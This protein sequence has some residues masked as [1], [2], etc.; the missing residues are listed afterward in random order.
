MWETDNTNIHWTNGDVLTGGPDIPSVILTVQQVMN[1][2]V[3]ATGTQGNTG[4]Q[5]ATGPSQWIN[6]NGIGPQGAGYTGIG[7]TGQD[8]L[9]Y[10]NL[11]VT[12]AID[13]TSL[14][15]SQ[16]TGGPQGSIWYDTNNFIRMDKM[17]IDDSTS[18]I[19]LDINSSLPQINLTDLS[20]PPLHTN[21]ITNER[22]SLYDG[23]A[24]YTAYIDLNE[25][26]SGNPYIEIR[27]MTTPDTQALIHSDFLYLLNSNAN[28]YDV[29]LY[30]DHLDFRDYTTPTPLISKTFQFNYFDSISTTY[31][32]TFRY[33]NASLTI[34]DGIKLVCDDGSGTPANALTITGN[35]RLISNVSTLSGKDSLAISTSDP[36]FSLTLSGGRGGATSNTYGTGG[37]IINSGQGNCVF[38]VYDGTTTINSFTVNPEGFI[39]QSPKVLANWNTTGTNFINLGAASYGVFEITTTTSLTLSSITPINGINGGNYIIKINGPPGISCSVTVGDFSS[40]CK[41]NSAFI[42]AG[43]FSFQNP[44]ILILRIY[45]DNNLGLYYINVEKFG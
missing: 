24:S 10:G 21:S 8:V 44:Q 28:S 29:Y 43:G 3:G 4:A 1:T 42:A 23:S 33:D 18:S 37:T 9:I 16:T 31:K 11:L 40:V 25:Q 32:N 14:S 19:S 20:S 39:L 15:F 22:I 5:G 27:K 2:Q 38:N 35:D 13:P 30:A 7:V 12:G 41:L 26:T 45:S 34:N 36:A 17:K 6:M